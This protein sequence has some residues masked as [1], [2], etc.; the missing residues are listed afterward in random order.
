MPG[1]SNSELIRK[2]IKLSSKDY[3]DFLNDDSRRA[4]GEIMQSTVALFP[5]KVDRSLKHKLDDERNVWITR[6]RRDPS[7]AVHEEKRR[8]ETISSQEV[9]PNSTTETATKEQVLS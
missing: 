8:R 4:G 2:R 9:T 6:R 7:E 3:L 1:A 5:Q